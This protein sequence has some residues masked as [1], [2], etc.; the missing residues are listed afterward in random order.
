MA[1]IG[2]FE[3]Y[4]DRYEEWFL[5]NSFAYQSELQ[6]IKVLL[7]LYGVGIEI[8][9]GSG[10]FAAPLGI[11]IGIEPS[12]VMRKRASE[13]GIEVIDGVAED[14][15]FQDERFDFALMVTTICFLDDIEASLKEAHRVLKPG[16]FLIIGFVDRESPLG[17]SYLKRAQENVF[18]KHATFYSVKEV[19]SYMKKSRFGN[20]AFT[21]T[22]F[23]DL[24]KI[25]ASE[26]VKEG[27][28]EGAFV[29][30]RGKKRL[31]RGKVN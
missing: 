3:K 8:G 21:Q 20:F 7:P 13:K 15:P 25:K 18:Y 29:V 5:K 10:R 24:E 31:L 23:Q 27:Y 16:G 4:A 2:P 6:A 9:V 28:G 30:V 12:E 11:K 26:P 14:L 19:V 22:I 1:K 17:Q